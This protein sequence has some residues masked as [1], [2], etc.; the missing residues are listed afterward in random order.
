[1]RAPRSC[2]ALTCIP[3]AMRGGRYHQ[4]RCRRARL[5]PACLRRYAVSHVGTR[6]RLPPGLTAHLPLLTA[7]MLLSR[8]ID[9]ISNNQHSTP[10]H[11]VICYLP[12]SYN[13][14]GL[15]LAYPTPRPTRF[16][17]SLRFVPHH[18]TAPTARTYTGTSCGYH[19]CNN[20]QRGGAGWDI[21]STM[22]NKTS[23]AGVVEIVMRSGTSRG[24]T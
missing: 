10:N 15:V 6:L 21:L 7:N 22:R 19:S 20:G 9:G 12:T 1:M 23:I 5:P 11:L 8:P 3:T 24:V 17:P 13:R 18:V 14:P 2:I 4:A 16:D